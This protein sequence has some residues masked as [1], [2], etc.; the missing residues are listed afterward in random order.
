M[1]TEHLSTDRNPEDAKR[2][3]LTEPPVA[4]GKSGIVCQHGTVRRDAVLTD[5]EQREARER[6]GLFTAPTWR[7]AEPPPCSHS[8][9]GRSIATTSPAGLSL[10]A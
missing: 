3:L 2:G 8:S 10:G 9:A 4:P 5:V 1:F 7:L 6:S